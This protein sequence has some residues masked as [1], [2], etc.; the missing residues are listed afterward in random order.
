MEL[1]VCGAETLDMQ[2]DA[3]PDRGHLERQ[4]SYSTVTATSQNTSL[5]SL[6]CSFLQIQCLNHRG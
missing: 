6:F 4:D 3:I 2:I 5:L 1:H